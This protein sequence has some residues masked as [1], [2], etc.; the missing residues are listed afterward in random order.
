MGN[1]RNAVSLLLMQWSYSSL[2]VLQDMPCCVGSTSMN[3]MGV[4]LGG[5]NPSGKILSLVS[6]STSITITKTTNLIT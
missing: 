1:H 3:I 5:T 6:D 2:D 4:R